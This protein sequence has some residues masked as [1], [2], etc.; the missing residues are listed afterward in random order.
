MRL[1]AGALVSGM[2][3]LGVARVMD[4]EH[5]SGTLTAVAPDMLAVAVED[6]TRMF[7]VSGVTIVS[8][9][10]KPSQVSELQAG[11]SVDIAAQSPGE[12]GM[13]MAMRVDAV[14]ND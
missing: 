3:M 2:L 12:D 8:L 6:E 13:Q 4:A 11:D 14:R 10:G 5:V 9:D 7:S 1:I